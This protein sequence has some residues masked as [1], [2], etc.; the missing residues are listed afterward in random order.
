MQS[1]VTL[2]D[3]RD[4]LLQALQAQARQNAG[5]DLTLS[6]VDS[7][8]YADRQNSGRYGAVPN[9]TTGQE[10]G[11]TLYFHYLPRDLGGSI[12]YSRTTAP[13]VLAWLND[14]ASTLDRQ[15]RF[16][17]YAGLQRFA[18]L[19]LAYGL[20]L[21]VPEDQ[22]AASTRVHGV[23]FRPFKQLP[24]NAYDIWVER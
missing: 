12:N 16:D 20:P 14:A 6:Y 4:L 24:E 23:G 9:S 7:G 11:L 5:I 3:Q 21:Y 19:E 10:D 17:A 2:R 15:K 22:I 8:T 18:L 1:Q 13:E